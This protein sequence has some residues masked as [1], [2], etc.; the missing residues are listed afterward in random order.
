[1]L[2]IRI[3]LQEF[4]GQIIEEQDGSVGDALEISQTL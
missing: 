1:V 4:E 2:V 3:V